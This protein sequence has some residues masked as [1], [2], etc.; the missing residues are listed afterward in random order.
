MSLTPSLYTRKILL[1]YHSFSFIFD[2]PDLNYYVAVSC[3]QPYCNSSLEMLSLPD[4]LLL[5]YLAPYLQLWTIQV[6][7]HFRLL[8]SVAPHRDRGTF[9]VVPESIV[10]ICSR[11]FFFC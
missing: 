4:A 8:V 5:F 3:S 10:I 7:I 9:N 6:S 2:I 1:M 11:C